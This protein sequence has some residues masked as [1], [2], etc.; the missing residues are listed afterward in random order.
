MRHIRELY[1][2][3]VADKEQAVAYD[4]DET[5]KLLNGGP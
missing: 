2:Q 4:P 5:A 3:R 1:E